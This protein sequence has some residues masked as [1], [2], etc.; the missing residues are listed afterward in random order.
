MSDNAKGIP[1]QIIKAAN[2]YTHEDMY[3]DKPSPIVYLDTLAQIMYEGYK[4]KDINDFSIVPLILVLE[5]DTI[6]DIKSKGVFKLDIQ[7]ELIHPLVT[8]NHTDWD[9][10]VESSKSGLGIGYMVSPE[11]KGVEKTQLADLINTISKIIELH[12]EINDFIVEVPPHSTTFHLS[13]IQWIT[14][15]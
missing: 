2:P 6:Y 3:L 14:K 8:L 10:L 11:S 15:K 5:K 1:I 12:G 4:Q 13:Y 9:Y 7:K